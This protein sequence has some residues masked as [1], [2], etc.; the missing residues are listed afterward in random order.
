MEV[1][2]KQFRLLP[3][4]RQMGKIMGEGWNKLGKRLQ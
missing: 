2:A 4:K 3:C 1:V